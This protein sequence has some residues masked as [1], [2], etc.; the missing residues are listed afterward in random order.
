M[1]YF[2]RWPFFI[3][4]MVFWLLFNFN[5][6]IDTIIYGVVIS[7]LMTI[8]TSQV[9]FDQKGYRYKRIRWLALF[10]YLLMLLIEIFKAAFMYIRSIIRGGYEV[11]VFD[12]KLTVDDPIEIALIANSITLTPGTISIDV[13]GQ[14]ITV[15]AVAK[16]GTPL[17]EI[18]G[19][20]HSQFEKIIKR[21]EK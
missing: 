17:S 3:A 9:L 6:N 5:F 7:V 18:E 21:A 1:T 14:V 2:K 11:I 20:M 10:K 15:L 12:L 16:I 8:F 19:P 13:N 4:M